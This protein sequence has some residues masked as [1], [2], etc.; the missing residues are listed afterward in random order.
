MVEGVR[1]YI[2]SRPAKLHRQLVE[3]IQFILEDPKR[4]GTRKLEGDEWIFEDLPIRRIQ[5]GDYRILYVA[6]I[7]KGEVKVI[8]VGL[9]RDIYGGH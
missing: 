6:D 3:K 7:T 8:D 2:E 1:E 4:P 9:R 5:C